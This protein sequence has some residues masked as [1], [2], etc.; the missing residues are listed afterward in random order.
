M[1]TLL[2]QAD[3]ARFVAEAYKHGKTVA[4]SDEGLSLLAEADVPVAPG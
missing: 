1:K 4:A 2:S 3:A